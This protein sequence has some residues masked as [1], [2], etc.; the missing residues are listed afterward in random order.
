MEVKSLPFTIPI[1]KV[2]LQGEGGDRIS[3]LR[4]CFEFEVIAI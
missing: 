1:S 2:S 4:F 3:N